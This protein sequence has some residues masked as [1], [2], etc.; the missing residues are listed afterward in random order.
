MQLHYDF[1]Q[2]ENNLSPQKGRILIS[3]PFLMDNYFKRSIVLLTEHSDEGT[4][5][6]S[7]INR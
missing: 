2:T 4:V 3:E 1:F 6:S 5:V 7:S